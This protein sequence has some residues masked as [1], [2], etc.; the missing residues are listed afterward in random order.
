ME[1]IIKIDFTGCGYRERHRLLSF[2][3]LLLEDNFNRIVDDTTTTL[4]ISYDLH[5]DEPKVDIGFNTLYATDY[6]IAFDNDNNACYTCP[7]D[8]LD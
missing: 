7:L 2:T 4:D 1:Q 5:Y 8:Y 6:E 3:N